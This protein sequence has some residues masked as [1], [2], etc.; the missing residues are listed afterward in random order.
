MPEF[1][2][3]HSKFFILTD[4]LKLTNLPFGNAKGE[5][6]QPSTFNL[7]TTNLKILKSFNP[8]SCV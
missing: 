8:K 5:Q 4:N 6:L 1:Y 2:I 3:I 7:K